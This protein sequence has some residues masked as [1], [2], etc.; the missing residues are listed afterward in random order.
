MKEIE[1]LVPDTSVIIENLV[2]QKLSNKEIKIKELLIHEAVMA[3]LEHQANFGKE[4]GRFGLDEL[5]FEGIIQE[6]KI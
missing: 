5:G 3:E 4:T 2:S 6:T 1:K